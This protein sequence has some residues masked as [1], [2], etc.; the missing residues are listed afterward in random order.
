M[1]NCS[2]TKKKRCQVL[3]KFILS[4]FGLL[5]QAFAKE[6]SPELK[7]EQE[8]IRVEQCSNQKEQ[9]AESL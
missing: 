5:K 6:M 2:C 4:G 7:D 3:L 1:K 8:F 9:S